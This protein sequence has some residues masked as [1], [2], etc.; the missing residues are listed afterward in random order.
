MSSEPVKETP[1]S[2]PSAPAAADQLQQPRHSLRRPEEAMLGEVLQ[3]PVPQV[4]TLILVR[5]LTT[6]ACPD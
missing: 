1:S 4:R 2:E 6:S 3:Q 5:H